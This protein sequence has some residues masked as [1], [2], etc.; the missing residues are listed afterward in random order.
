MNKIYLVLV[1]CGVLLLGLSS[2]D[3]GKT[4]PP[5]D[6]ESSSATVSND[7]WF[8]SDPETD[9]SNGPFGDETYTNGPQID[10]YYQASRNEYLAD[11]VR[12]NPSTVIVKDPSVLKIH[13]G[14]LIPMKTGETYIAC[15][16]GQEY[17]IYP[18]IIHGGAENVYTGL[19]DGKA[20]S[21]L[22]LFKLSLPLCK[23]VEVESCSLGLSAEV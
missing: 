21:N 7:P 4:D 19:V 11:H 1:L 12:I 16:Y 5:H 10:L 3:L 2:C 18:V 20:T 6:T 8:P 9:P 13:D 15:Q 23:N 14:Q 17:V 22:I